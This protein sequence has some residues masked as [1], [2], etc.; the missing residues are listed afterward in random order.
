[1][2]LQVKMGPH[3]AIRR[4]Q[5]CIP[6]GETIIEELDFQDSDTLF[7]TDHMDG[8]KNSNNNKDK[9]SSTAVA[10]MEPK[11]GAS[12]TTGGTAKK[13][14]PRKYPLPH[15][16]SI[17]IGGVPVLESKDLSGIREETVSGGTNQEEIERMEST[18]SDITEEEDLEPEAPLMPTMEIEQGGQEVKVVKKT[19]SGFLEVPEVLKEESEQ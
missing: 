3:E 5:K 19:Q 10:D 4:I 6:T 1:M 2:L 18:L 14:P 11:G 7:L 9:S 15:R 12:A 13:M 17:C 16:V 8:N